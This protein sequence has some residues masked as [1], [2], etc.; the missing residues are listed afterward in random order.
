MIQW[1]RKHFIP[2]EGNDHQPHFLRTKNIRFLLSL[3]FVL[4]LSVFSLPFISALNPANNNYLA[5]ILPAVLDDLTN[6]NRQSE[7]LAVLTVNPVLNEVAQLKANDM[8][9]KS[10]FAHVSPEGKTPW[11]WFRQVG[12]KYVYA[13]EN[14]AVD[15]SDSVDVDTAWMNSPTHRANILKD[16]YTEMGTG[17]ATGTY[18]GHTTVFVAQEFGKPASVDISDTSS[19]IVAEATPLP[20]PVSTPKVA[21]SSKVEGASVEVV[22]KNLKSSSSSVATETPAVASPTINSLPLQNYSKTNIFE[23]YLTSPRHIINIILSIL[24]AL[25]ILAILLKLFIRADKKHPILITNGLIILA[26]IFGIY[27]ANNYIA[28]S[29]LDTT[30]SFA[31]FH[32]E[33]FD[34]QTK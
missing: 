15:F 2:H 5:S 30:A 29:K 9:A 21:V 10:Y 34:Q 14:L 26:I 11:Y 6:Q 17:I 12:Y 4:E 31:S 23:K 27:V 1:F 24:A 28:T 20:T 3:V 25:I 8:A 32:G 22:D 16:A 33:Q 13:G 7:H 19:Q 18:Q